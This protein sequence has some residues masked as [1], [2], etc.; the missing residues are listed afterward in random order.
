MHAHLRNAKRVHTCLYIRTLPSPLSVDLYQE[1][2]KRFTRSSLSPTSDWERFSSGR[3]S[4]KSRATP[5]L[6]DNGRRTSCKSAP[7][8]SPT[9]P[10][11]CVTVIVLL[12]S[13]SFSLTFRSLDDYYLEATGRRRSSGKL[14]KKEHELPKLSINICTAYLSGICGVRK[15]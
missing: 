11:C 4:L 13:F 3:G 8:P 9:P 2:V 14:K 6:S 5:T 12:F 15:R 10:A 7:P 1:T